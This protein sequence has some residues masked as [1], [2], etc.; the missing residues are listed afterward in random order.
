MTSARTAIPVVGTDG[1]HL[2]LLEDF[3]KHGV[4]VDEIAHHVVDFHLKYNPRKVLV[5]SIVAQVAVADAIKRVSNDFGVKIQMDE[6][7]SHGR[8]K[9]DWRIYGLEPYFKKQLFYIHKSHHNFLEEYTSFPLGKLRDILDALSFQRTDWELAFQ[10]GGNTG[11]GAE[12]ERGRREAM[13]R[14]RRNLGARTYS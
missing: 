4:N 5:E 6:I 11:W 9:K 8:N 7:K 1:T 14:V 2:F 3:A 10:H 12:Q 13:E